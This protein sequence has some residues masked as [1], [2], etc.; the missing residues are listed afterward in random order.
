[1]ISDRFEEIKN[2]EKISLSI[3]CGNNDVQQFNFY[4]DETTA[5]NISPKKQN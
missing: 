1:M 5:E 3:N 4:V 2:E